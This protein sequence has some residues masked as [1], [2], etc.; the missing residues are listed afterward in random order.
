ML[1]GP[2]RLA[3]VLA[4]MVHVTRTMAGGVL[5]VWAIF[6][7]LSRLVLVFSVISQ[8][9]LSLNTHVSVVYAVAILFI[10]LSFTLV[11]C[12]IIV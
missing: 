4:S 7:H 11:I 3:A 12:N 2:P 8:E 6:D 1:G 10:S 9:F 5:G